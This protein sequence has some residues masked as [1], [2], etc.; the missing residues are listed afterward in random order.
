VAGRRQ[1]STGEHQEVPP[2]APAERGG[3]GLTEETAR[4]VG[5]ERRRCGGVHKWWRHSGDRW[6]LARAPATPYTEG[7]RVEGRFGRR[8]RGGRAH[9]EAVAVAMAVR[10]VAR[11]G[12]GVGTGADERSKARGGMTHGALRGKNGGGDE[13]GRG[14]DLFKR[15]HREQKGGSRI[16]VRVGQEKKGEGG[17]GTVGSVSGG[18][19]SQIGESGGAQPTRCGRD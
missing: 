3:G 10:Q 16:G 8:T 1:G 17:Y 12:R 14:G 6:G 5:A 7:V 9:R 2:S 11:R 18:A 4:W 13:T 15:R 19:I